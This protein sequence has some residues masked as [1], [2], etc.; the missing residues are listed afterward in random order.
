VDFHRQLGD[1]VL[2]GCAGVTRGW[3]LQM[4]WGLNGMGVKWDGEWEW[5][6]ENGGGDVR[7]SGWG[8]GIMEESPPRVPSRQSP[9]PM[10]CLSTSHMFKV[11]VLPI[12][13]RSKAPRKRIARNIG[14]TGCEVPC[15]RRGG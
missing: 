11:C 6:W 5:E 4:G 10:P 1:V 8:S 3:G 12:Y 2:R 7:V 15:S 13:R 14:A 9:H